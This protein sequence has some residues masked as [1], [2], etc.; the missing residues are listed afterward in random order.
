MP[1]E[2]GSIASLLEE[3]LIQG[4]I[5]GVCGAILGGICVLPGMGCSSLGGLGGFFLGYK[6]LFSSLFESCPLA[7]I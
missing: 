3:P 2:V 1:I 7:R 5:A 6:G 4:I